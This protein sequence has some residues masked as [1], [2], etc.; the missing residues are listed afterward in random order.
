[1]RVNENQPGTYR[2][3]CGAVFTA[4]YR[5]P[6]P[7]DLFDLGDYIACAHACAFLIGRLRDPERALMALEDD[8]LLHELLHLASGIPVCTFHAPADIRVQVEW[9]WRTYHRLDAPPEPFL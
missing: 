4:Q 2:T 5:G 8:G 6:S 1:M 7:M 3:R 9:L